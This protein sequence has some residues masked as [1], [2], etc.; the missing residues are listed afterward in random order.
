M[1]NRVGW[2][3]SC[4]FVRDNDNVIRDERSRITGISSHHE[5]L[6]ELP[7]K[8]IFSGHFRSNFNN[9]QPWQ[10]ICSSFVVCAVLYNLLQTHTLPLEKCLTLESY[11]KCLW[12]FSTKINPYKA[13]LVS[14]RVNSVHRPKW[15]NVC[16]FVRFLLCSQRARTSNNVPRVSVILD[17]VLF[18]V[19]V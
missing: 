13:I 17:C 10:R 2:T 6:S 11:H 19:R 15:A 7:F 14:R 4:Y 18:W 12:V 5:Q 16:V 1:N 9:L 8:T 3:S